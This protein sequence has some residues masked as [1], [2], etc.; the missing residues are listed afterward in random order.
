[1]KD[2]F[3]I[4]DNMDRLNGMTTFVEVVKMGSF[5]LAAEKLNLSR[6]QV[7]KTIMQ[8]EAHL[9]TRLL[10]RTTR[11][12]SLNEIGQIYYE[13]CL[14]IL[15]DIDDIEGI[16]RQ[17]ISK[18]KGS[19]RMSV[20]SSFGLLHLNEAIPEYIKQYPDV[21]I[22]L[23]LADRFIDVI[24]EGFDLVIRIGELNDS[25][26]IAR[27]VAPCRRVF[28]ATPEYLKQHGNPLV[29]RD[30]INHNCLIYTNE[31]SA[32]TW[33]ITGPEKTESVKI[34][35]PLCSDNGQILRDAALADLGIVIMPTFIVGDDIIRGDL[36]QILP[37]YYFPEI[38]IY[39]VF[40]SRRYLSAKVRT[41]IDFLSDYFGETPAYD[42]F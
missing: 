5:T 19:L 37:G 15:Q 18:P 32:D 14:T 24:A 29:P 33:T 20:P 23:S 21:K 12:I 8:L 36:Q 27:K 17:Q 28:C 35:G 26:L 9:D 41:F 2:C 11:T 31:N 34:T 16:T 4:V 38:S 13:R 42:Q 30:L 22:E 1:M 40:P 25:G 6:A 10:N 3:F 7:S 39:V